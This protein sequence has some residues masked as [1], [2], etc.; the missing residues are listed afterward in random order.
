[1]VSGLFLQAQALGPEACILSGLCAAP[2]GGSP[3]PSGVMF[4]AVGLVALGV[5]RWRRVRARTAAPG[6]IPSPT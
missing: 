1:M 5:W 6:D 2:D 4:A 3:I